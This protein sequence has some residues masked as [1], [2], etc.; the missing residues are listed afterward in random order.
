MLE[1]IQA[2]SVLY[3]MVALLFL[4]FLSS[5]AFGGQL[6]RNLG[7]D[8]EPKFVAIATV[9]MALLWPWFIGDIVRAYEGRRPP[10]DE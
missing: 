1:L 3:G 4:I 2:L 5:M 8:W 10:E 6:E 9:V 7:K